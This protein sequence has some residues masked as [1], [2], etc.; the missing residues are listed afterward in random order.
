[1]SRSYRKFP[2]SKESHCRD[3]SPMKAK[4]FANR[5]VRRSK[6]I[7]TGKGGYKKLYDSYFISDYRYIGY[8]NK[9][10]VLKGWEAEDYIYHDTYK[11][12]LWFW[13]KWY[14]RK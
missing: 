3:R 5:A 6:E 14:I 9:M 1:M 11:E 2:I 13:K 10:E 4:D 7:P 12:A 8:M